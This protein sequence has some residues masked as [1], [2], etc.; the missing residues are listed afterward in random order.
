M[1]RIAATSGFTLALACGRLTLRFMNKRDALPLRCTGDQPP[2]SLSRRRFLQAAGA[3]A[4]LAGLSSAAVAAQNNIPGFERS[5]DSDAMHKDWKPV[6]DRKVRVGIVGYG[7]CRF[8]A[9]FGFQNHP[10]VEVVAVSDLIPERCEGLAKACRCS[11]T[12]PSLEELVKDD[13]IEAVFVA[14]DA[15]SHA[16]HCIEV[17]KHG[18]HVA[19]A[20][21]AVFGSLEQADQLFQAVKAARGL[22][23]MMFETSCYHADLHAMRQLYKAGALGK[24]VYA[25][26]EYYHY[27]E[28]PIP[29]FKDWRVGLPP[30]YYPTHSNAYYCGVTGGSFTEVCCMGFPSEIPHL[31]P[32]GN[33]YRNPFGTEIAQFRTSEGGVARMAVSWDTPGFGGEMGRIRGQKGTFYDKYEGLNQKLPEQRRPALPPA[34]SPGGHGGSHGYLT[35]EF[36]AAILQDRQPLVNIEMAL[37]LTVSGIVAHHS[38]LKDGE[39][40]KIP[41]YRL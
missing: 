5:A 21:P 11:K 7:V 36:I 33:G 17:L 29:S 30:Q 23:Y 4:C 13:R 14:T 9:D 22:K 3:T 1:K 25:E 41:Q 40:L 12:Y 16:R 10:N 32:E 27:M 38:A 37:N 39:L 26:G 2:L 20:V 8:G 19:S 18:K 35:D 6:S 28:E 31:R 15:P 24:L 34:V